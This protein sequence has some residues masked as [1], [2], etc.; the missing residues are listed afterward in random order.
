[1][2]ETTQ[3]RATAQ[4][5]DQANPHGGRIDGNTVEDAVLLERDLSTLMEFLDELWETDA[6]DAVWEEFDRRK[7][8]PL[9]IVTECVMWRCRQRLRDGYW[10]FDA[11]ERY[12]QGEGA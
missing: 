4:P 12:L 9:R 3:A 8:A 6:Q 11:Y 5:A 2:S 1:M 7:R 10:D